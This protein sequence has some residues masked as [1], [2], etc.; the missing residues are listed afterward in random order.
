MICSQCN[1]EFNP[2]SQGQKYCSKK[3]YNII[4]KIYNKNYKQSDKYK[5]AIKKYRQSD[6]G[7]EATKIARNKYRQSDKGKESLKKYNQS[8][9]GKKTLK[10]YFENMSE[11]KKAKYKNDRSKFFLNYYR[12]R[13]KEPLFRLISNLRSRTSIILKSKTLRKNSG[14]LKIL[15]CTLPE[16]KNH[17][18]KKFLPGMN[19][20]NNSSDGWHVDHI[21]PISS[22]KTTEGIIRLCHYKNL[23]PLWAAE[24]IRKGNKII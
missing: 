19:W 24:N 8:D 2:S 9:A 22:A 23:Q 16:L 20:S 11:E 12:K 6:K 15:G 17:L 3:C 5:E 10:D 1:K 4:L 13:R 21:I 7:K 18:E 14:M